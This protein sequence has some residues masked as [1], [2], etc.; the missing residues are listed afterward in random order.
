MKYIWEPEDI[1]PGRGVVKAKISN[2]NQMKS[3]MIGYTHAL[4]TGQDFEARYFLILMDEDG[5]C[6]NMQSKESLAEDL[7]SGNYIPVE[8]LAPQTAQGDVDGYGQFREIK[9]AFSTLTR[10]VRSFNVRGI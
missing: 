8:V 4:A 6:L 2:V 3:Y 10:V 5:M 9:K 7:T 1:I